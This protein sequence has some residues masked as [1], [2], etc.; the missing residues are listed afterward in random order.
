VG[1]DAPEEV[2]MGQNKGSLV[3]PWTMTLSFMPFFCVA[4]MR[5]AVGCH[6][7]VNDFRCAI[8][9]ALQKFVAIAIQPYIAQMKQCACLVF[10]M[11]SPGGT[12][13]RSQ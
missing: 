11:F 12:R 1:N 2:Q 10:G 13:R 5:D 7:A 9:V 6:V 4:K 8:E 3:M